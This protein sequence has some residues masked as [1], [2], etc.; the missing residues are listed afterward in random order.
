MQQLDFRATG[1]R[2]RNHLRDSCAVLSSLLE[3]VYRAKTHETRDI[4]RPEIVKP[5][6]GKT[7]TFSHSGTEL[8]IIWNSERKFKDAPEGYTMVLSESKFAAEWRLASKEGRF[9]DVNGIISPPGTRYT[10]DKKTNSPIYR[11]SMKPN[12]AEGRA[13]CFDSPVGFSNGDVKRHL[14]GEE[15]VKLMVPLNLYNHKLAEGGTKILSNAKKDIVIGP[16]N[17]EFSAGGPLSRQDFHLHERICEIYIAFGSVKVFYISKEGR[18]EYIEESDG[19]AIV[20]KPGTPHYTILAGETP[21]FVM[22]GSPLP[23]FGDK[24]VVL[25]HGEITALANAFRAN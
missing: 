22:M 6:P 10:V 12:G 16:S 20:V 24:H 19:N 1:A 18:I 11:A 23:L 5:E 8:S 21:S 15:P 7:V 2:E 25:P 17:Q 3:D 4:S 13:L 9:D 14:F